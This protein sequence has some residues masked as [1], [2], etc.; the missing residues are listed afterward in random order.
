MN[1]RILLLSL[2]AVI[3]A[4]SASALDSYTLGDLGSDALNSLA[5]VGADIFSHWILLLAAAAA[6]GIVVVFLLLAFI[7]IRGF[8]P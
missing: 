8:R 1:Q 5:G 2:M 6:L 4:G 7:F 3:L